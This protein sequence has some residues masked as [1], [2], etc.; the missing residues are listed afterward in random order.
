MTI[1]AK[2]NIFKTMFSDGDSSRWRMMALGSMS[3]DGSVR[4][5]LLLFVIINAPIEIRRNFLRFPTPYHY[6]MINATQGNTEHSLRVL[7]SR[8]HI[9]DNAMSL[10][11]EI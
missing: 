2:M 5:L 10:C 3:R 11:R 8:I 4:F 1:A 6:C 7:I 9:K